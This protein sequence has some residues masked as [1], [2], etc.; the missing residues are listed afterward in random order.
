MIKF[1]SFPF[2]LQMLVN[3][4]AKMLFSWQ[5]CIWIA[6]KYT[7]AKWMSF[8]KATHACTNEITIY[9]I[10]IEYGLSFNAM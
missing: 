9:P 6:V 10:F 4:S 8:A 1:Y 5:I 2:I 3:D 7:S